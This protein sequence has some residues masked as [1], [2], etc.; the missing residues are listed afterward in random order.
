MI[1]HI[2][3]K[4]LIGHTFTGKSE[5]CPRIVIKHLHFS[6][7]KD[8][9]I[10]AISKTGNTVTGEIVTACKPGTKTP[11]NTFFV[12]ILP[13]EN[14]KFVKDIEY[15]YNQ[16]VLIEE[17]KRKT[18]IVQCTR[19]QQ[20]SHTKNNC[21][22]PYRCVK[23]AGAHN[24]TLCTI[25]KNTPATC[26]LCLGNHPASYKGCQIYKEILSRK[27][28]NKQNKL[29]SAKPINNKGYYRKD[30][31]LSREAV[32]NPSNSTVYEHKQMENQNN[33]QSVREDDAYAINWPKI[34]QN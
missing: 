20:Y 18:A 12:N 19:C 5:R 34:R 15:I 24:T 26:A 25:D 28:L 31:S 14:N 27:T 17:P 32:T 23:C 22:R 3:S 2:R 11:I 33:R 30:N 29:I 9:I 1:E 21:M 10:E 7:P 16:K 4:G 8:A 6:T 13:H